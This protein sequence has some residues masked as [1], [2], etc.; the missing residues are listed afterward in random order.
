[1][2]TSF[3]K[4]RQVKSTYNVSKSKL[5]TANRFK[6]RV[7]YVFNNQVRDQKTMDSLVRIVLDSTTTH[8]TIKNVTFY[9]W[10]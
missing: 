2:F 8:W 7:I 1:M 9:F 5:P 10:L 4:Y 6:V 3:C